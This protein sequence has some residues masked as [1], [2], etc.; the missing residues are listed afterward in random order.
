[1]APFRPVSALIAVRVFGRLVAMTLPAFVFLAAVASAEPSDTLVCRGHEP[2]WSLSIDGS[3]ATLRTLGERGTMQVALNG[4]LREASARPLSLVYRG[5]ADGWDADLVAVITREACSDT[6][7]EAGERNGTSDYTVRLSLPDGGVRQGCC[8]RAAPPAEA[9]A[10][11]SGAAAEAPRGEVVAITLA[12][13]RECRSTGRGAT[14]ASRGRRLSFDCGFRDGDRLGIVGPLGTSPN[15]FLV[16][17]RAVIAWR[18]SGSAAPDPEPAAARVSE[19]AL[20]DGL[21]CREPGRGPALVFDGRRASFTCGMKDG[22]T[23][24]LLGDLEPA[25][26]GFR[27]LRARIGESDTG[28]VVRSSE[29]VL[30]AAPR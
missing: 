22:E 19:I 3:S 29:I 9:G 12:D 25:P 18:E 26:G 28:F 23:V 1:M 13:D 8:G 14:L 5:R 15:G 20:A 2:A 24:A 30:L 7:A 6:I 4:R 16:A 17:H 27:V 11:A 21:T 10:A